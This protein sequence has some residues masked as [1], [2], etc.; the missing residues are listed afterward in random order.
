MFTLKEL[1]LTVLKCDYTLSL[2]LC[3]SIHQ[4][5]EILFL[6]IFISA[7]FSPVKAILKIIRALQFLPIIPLPGGGIPP[8]IIECVEEQD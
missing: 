1:I 7:L 5:N 6:G 2:S 3:H 4:T 8:M